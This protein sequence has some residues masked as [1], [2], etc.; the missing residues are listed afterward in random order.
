MALLGLFF[1]VLPLVDGDKDG[2]FDSAATD[3]LRAVFER[4]VKKFAETGFGIVYGP[5]PWGPL[6]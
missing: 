1:Q 6:E 5:E 2:G 3:D 4:S